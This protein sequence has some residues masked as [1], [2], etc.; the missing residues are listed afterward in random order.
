MASKEVIKEIPIGKFVYRVSVPENFNEVQTERYVN[1]LLDNG[2]YDVIKATAFTIDGKPYEVVGGVREDFP[3]FKDP[4]FKKRLVEQKLVSPYGGNHTFEKEQEPTSDIARVLKGAAA[5]A[6]NSFTLGGAGLIS[7]DIKNTR[8][9][10]YKTNPNTALLSEIAGFLGTGGVGALAKGVGR[11]G[12][13]LASKL[14]LASSAAP[15]AAALTEAAPTLLNSLKYGVG[16]VVD[17]IVG[18]GADR[19]VKEGLLNSLLRG[20]GTGAATGGIYEAAL[21]DPGERLDEGARGAVTGGIVGG[22]A[23]PAIRGASSL[24]KAVFRRPEEAALLNTTISSEELNNIL[25]RIKGGNTAPLAAQNP[26]LSILYENA[27]RKLP[28]SVSSPYLTQLENAALAEAP[29]ARQMALTDLLESTTNVVPPNI[30]E[31]APSQANRAVTSSLANRRAAELANVSERIN[32]L[33]NIQ[34]TSQEAQELSSMLNR[35]ISDDVRIAIETSKGEIGKP[36]LNW[37]DNVATAR[38]IRPADLK[39]AID[40]LAEIAPKA[41]ASRLN[42]SSAIEYLKNMSPGLQKLLSDYQSSRAFTE[43]LNNFVSPLDQVPGTLFG[44]AKRGAKEAGFKSLEDM[45]EMPDI[46]RNLDQARLNITQGL[47]LRGPEHLLDGGAGFSDDALSR[48][49]KLYNEAD[50][51][52]LNALDSSRR[53]QQTT[54]LL[55][56]IVNPPS[57]P[58]NVLAADANPDILTSI[59]ANKKLSALGEDSGITRWLKESL[60]GSFDKTLEQS[61]IAKGLD[62]LTTKLR[63]KQVVKENATIPLKLFNAIQSTTMKALHSAAAQL[64]ASKQKAMLE[65]LQQGGDEAIQAVEKMLRYKDVNR[66]K[67]QDAEDLYR[68][69]MMLNAPALN[70]TTPQ[71]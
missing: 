14:G 57:V 53:D 63:T 24:A 43:H 30:L 15:K 13:G 12:T 3:L 11:L 38:S 16:G 52:A 42:L 5:T 23:L 9:E 18:R 68:M 33:P 8:K 60:G 44:G 21:A 62:D 56:Q 20:V 61:K 10:F 29:K 31:V 71:S 64:G 22:V 47:R 49:S 48:M 32:Q 70:A 27:Y 39:S 19:I 36:L 35:L 17:N 69:L 45:V 6:A 50:I 37:I 59:E 67:R 46:G 41:E 26:E 1:M 28:S 58:R 4:E 34:L 51:P 65:L 54:A 55:N 7:D 2:D 25:N 66:L 40:S